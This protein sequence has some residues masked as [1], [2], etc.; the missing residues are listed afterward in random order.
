VNPRARPARIQGIVFRAPRGRLNRVP[1]CTVPPLPLGVGQ[2]EPAITATSA[3]VREFAG[4]MD[5]IGVSEENPWR[6]SFGYAIDIT[7]PVASDSVLKN[8]VLLAVVVPNLT[9]ERT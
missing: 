8:A 9:Y 3:R 6:R 4:G 5:L 1:N 2:P 7:T